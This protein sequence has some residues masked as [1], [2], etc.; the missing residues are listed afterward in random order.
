MPEQELCIQKVSVLLGKIVANNFLVGVLYLSKFEEQET[1][2]KMS[3]SYFSMKSVLADSS[4]LLS[5]D[6]VDQTSKIMEA[7]HQ[8]TFL[9]IEHLKMIEFES[10][11]VE[12]V[13]YC[14][15]PLLA[16]EV[17]LNPSTDTHIYVQELL[18]IQRLKGFSM[19][20]LYSEIIRACLISLNNVNGTARDSIWS[21]FTFIKVPHIL[22][23]LH[24][25]TQ[26]ESHFNVYTY[27]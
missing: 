26:S 17:L 25:Q 13:T 19:A 24:M 15:Q 1:F 10:N 8:I 14:L 12:N 2:A 20:R 22:K 27:S 3:K 18:M 7:L 23:Q 4:N 21:A 16:V 11:D 6:L 9:K 5:Q